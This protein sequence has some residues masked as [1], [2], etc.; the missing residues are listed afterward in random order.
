MRV[1]MTQDGSRIAIALDGDLVFTT[2]DGF[3]SELRRV[4]GQA[5]EIVL[6]LER[7]G[8]IDSSGVAAILSGYEDACQAGVTIRI[9]NVAQDLLEIFELIGVKDVLPFE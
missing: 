7:V 6:D 1:D 3:D 5:Q 4:M 2:R 9:T 8:F